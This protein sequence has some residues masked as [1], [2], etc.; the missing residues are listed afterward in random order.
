LLNSPL[1]SPFFLFSGTQNGVG[2]KK[3]HHLVKKS[4]TGGGKKHA[5]ISALKVLICMEA[6]GTA[7]P[8]H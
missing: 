5:L 6:H 1:P 4:F 3:E 2:K 8:E 7:Q